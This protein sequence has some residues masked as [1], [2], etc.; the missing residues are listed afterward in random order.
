MRL[1]NE[2]ADNQQCLLHHRDN[3]DFVFQA[4]NVKKMLNDEVC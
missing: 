3:L 4:H 1:K 2:M